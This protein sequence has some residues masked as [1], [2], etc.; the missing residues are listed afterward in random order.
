M[1]AFGMGICSLSAV[2]QNAVPYSPSTPPPM[3]FHLGNPTQQTITTAHG[4]NQVLQSRDGMLAY[5]YDVPNR[6]GEVPNG[7]RYTPYLVLSRLTSTVPSNASS[8]T[9][10]KQTLDSGRVASSFR[11]QAL[12][13]LGHER[14]LAVLYEPQFSPDGRYLL[15]KL[16]VPWSF[17]TTYELYVFDTVT[18]ALRRACTQEGNYELVSWSPD[19]NYIAFMA[20]GDAAGQVKAVHL[21][22]VVYTGPIRLYVCEWHTGKVTQ[23]ASNDTLRGPFTWLAPHTLF[24]G[25]LPEVEVSP[26][27][28][29]SAK[30]AVTP[31]PNVYEYDVDLHASR[32]T[33]QDAYRPMA[34][35]DGKWIAFYGSEHPDAPF[36]LRDG[37]EDAPQGAALAVA[38][39]NGS[40]RVALNIEGG[41]YAF[42]QWLPT[43]L[44][45]IPG[46]LTVKQTRYGMNNEAEVREWN[47][48]TRHFRVVATLRAHD[49]KFSPRSVIEPQFLPLSL[50]SDGKTLLVQVVELIGPDPMYP[51]IGKMTFGV[52]LIRQSLQAVDLTSGRV[53]V[54]TQ[55]E[56]AHGLAWHE[57]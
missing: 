36:M 53:S 14:S 37:W 41:P 5:T 55:V 26:T 49:Y 56:G 3:S 25:M 28:P 16:G 9:T 10:Q 38:H 42:L 22:E 31:R 21:S 7:G 57:K 47:I 48:T 46:L 50:S 35:P 30:R 18:R 51:P 34:A 39:R 6:K 8:G 19:G 23:V 1:A 15:L 43:D 52:N 44:D 12:R 11:F 40:E 2:A 20:G 27:K 54:I 32:L 29:K 24:Y 13:N 4:Q 45:E 33:L 17:D